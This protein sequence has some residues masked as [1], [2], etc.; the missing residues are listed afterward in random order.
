MTLGAD[1]VQAA[2]GQHPYVTALPF[3]FCTL[4]HRRLGMLAERRELGLETTAE[5]DGGA[6][7]RH[8]G[9][10]GHPAGAAGLRYDLCL[11]LVL[12]GVEHLMLDAL[13]IKQLRE[14]L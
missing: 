12:F 13:L 8:I 4:D 10:D 11:A 6:A 5:H 3:F 2:R 9:G 1:D 7:A 14:V